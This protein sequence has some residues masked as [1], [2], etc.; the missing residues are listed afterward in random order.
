[1]TATGAHATELADLLAAAPTRRM[2]RRLHRYVP[3]LSYA[4]RSPPTFLYSSG[5]AGRCSPAGVSCLY[6]AEDETVAA[7][8]YRRFWRGLPAEHQPRLAYTARVRLARV[9]DLAL[10]ETLGAL[11]LSPDHLREAWRGRP[12]TRLQA[13]GATVATQRAV[14]AIR[15]PS[16]A[17]RASGKAGWN[18]AIFPDAVVAPDRVEILGDSPAPLEALP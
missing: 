12:I 9:L 2:A 4:R 16:A 3:L 11:A 8:E 13:L 6:F 17:T 10:D 14:T 15:Y 18:V 7:T 5:R 1:V